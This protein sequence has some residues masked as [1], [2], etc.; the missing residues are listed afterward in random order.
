MNTKRKKNN[1]YCQAL[2]F[3]PDNFGKDTRDKRMIATLS[4]MTMEISEVKNQTDAKAFLEENGYAVSERYLFSERGLGIAKKTID[5]E[6]VEKIGI[7]GISLCIEDQIWV[8]EQIYIGTKVNIEKF[9]TFED[10]YNK[11]KNSSF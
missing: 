2:V 9:K 10:A 6:G 11:L 8:I 4:G 5:S 3:L 1:S 7:L